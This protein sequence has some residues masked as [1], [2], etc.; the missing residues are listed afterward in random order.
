[1]LDKPLLKVNKFDLDASQFLFQKGDSTYSVINN[2]K[3]NIE[4]ESNLIS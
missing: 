2:N 4:V 1:M 3:R